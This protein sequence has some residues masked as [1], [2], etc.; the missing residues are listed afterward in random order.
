M[1]PYVSGVKKKECG[2]AVE[3][4]AFTNLEKAQAFQHSIVGKGHAKKRKQNTHTEVSA[5]KEGKVS[6]DKNIILMEKKDKKVNDVLITSFLQTPLVKQISEEFIHIYV[7]GSY[8]HHKKIGGGGI[9][10]VKDN[11]ILMRDFIRCTLDTTNALSSVGME[12]LA[13]KRA[14]ELAIANSYTKIIIHYDF[15]G[16]V[17]CLN[18]DYETKDLETKNY[19]EII[20]VYSKW[21]EVQFQ[22][23]KAHSGNVFHDVADQLAKFATRM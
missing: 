2:F 21:V 10:F 12:R 20:K 5:K 11:L 18:E 4:R 13:V 7:D 6:K 16:I 17:D 9:V 23:E 3:Y 8:D 1:K 19:K 15:N 14:I 22:K